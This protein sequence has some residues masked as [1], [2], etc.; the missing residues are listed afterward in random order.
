MM[1]SKPFA[2][3]TL[4]STFQ[5]VDVTSWSKDLTVEI[6]GDDVINHAGAAALRVIADRTGLTSGLS[7]AL[8]R[9]GFVRFMIGAGC[10][11]TPRC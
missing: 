5:V 3:E 9:P 1:V 8:A 6:A 2:R 10:W 7:R 11:R 4:R